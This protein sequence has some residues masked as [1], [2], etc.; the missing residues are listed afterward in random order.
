MTEDIKAKLVS[1][2]DRIREVNLTQDQDFIPLSDTIYKRLLSDIAESEDRLFYYLRILHE[3]HFLFRIHIIEADERLKVYG[4]DG[5]V[6]AEESVVQ[7][8]RD[9][10]SMLL[11]TIYEGEFR[12][13]RSSSTIIH[14]LILKIQQYRGTPM[15][16][17]LNAVVMIQQFQQLMKEKPNE[18]QNDWRNTK[19]DELTRGMSK[20]V[21]QG[22]TEGE[23]V[24]LGES[25]DDFGEGEVRDEPLEAE[26]SI[27]GRRAVDTESYLELEKMDLSGAW[28]GAVEKF[29]VNF[30][31]RVHL[32]KHE[33]ALLRKLIKQKRI[34]REKD[35]RFIRD[36]LRTLETRAEE[37]PGLMAD[38]HEMKELRRMAQLRL[39]QI[40][41]MKRDMGLD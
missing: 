14:E 4:L 21:V 1:I 36:T 29:G 3:A 2:V 26:P 7:I 28:G 37:E 9:K 23:S 31:L 5:F 33:F 11:E 39:N 25:E 6:V 38:L 16:K 34:A 8:V 17:A 27:V 15:G 22:K 19:L 13:K 18:Y 30:L 32:R 10:S 24:D 40:F 12:K 20:G 35:L 41:I